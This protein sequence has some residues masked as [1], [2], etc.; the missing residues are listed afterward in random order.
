MNKYKGNHI[1]E[2]IEFIQISKIEEVF[3][4]VFV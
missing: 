4:K 2:D 3:E 1:L